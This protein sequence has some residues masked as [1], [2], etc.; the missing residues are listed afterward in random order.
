MGLL[1]ILLIGKITDTNVLEEIFKISPLMMFFGFLIFCTGYV[2]DSIRTIIV[3]K[4]LGYKINFF[5]ALEIISM[6]VV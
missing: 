1:V 2:V 4:V 3:L 6:A 5:D